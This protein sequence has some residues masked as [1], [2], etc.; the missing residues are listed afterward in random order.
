MSDEQKGPSEVEQL[1]RQAVELQAQIDLVTHHLSAARALRTA[2]ITCDS[3]GWPVSVQRAFNQ[4]DETLKKLVF[5]TAAKDAAER[6][7]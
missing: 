1:R 2:L 4:W 5:I 3:V 7:E 6:K